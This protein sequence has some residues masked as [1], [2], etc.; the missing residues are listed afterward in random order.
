MLGGCSRDNAPNASA[1]NTPAAPAKAINE[2]AS[3][4]LDLDTV[5]RRTHFGDRGDGHTFSAGHDSYAVEASAETLPIWPSSPPPTSDTPADVPNAPFVASIESIQRGGQRLSRTSSAVAAVREDATLA[6]TRGNVA[7]HLENNEEGVEQSFE[8]ATRPE[9]S[10]DLEINIAVSGQSFVGATEGGLHFIDPVSAIGVR[11]GEA[12]WVDAQGTRT[13][14]DADFVDGRIVLRVPE[15]LLDSSVY[16]AVLDP[17]IGPEIAIDAPVIFPGTGG[18]QFDPAVSYAGGQYLVVWTDMRFAVE[19]IYGVRVSATGTLLDTTGVPISIAGGVQ[20]NPVV[21]TDGTNWMVAWG[22]QAEMFATRITAAGA[23][24]D[25]NGITVSVGANCNTP[26][27]AFDGTNYFIAYAQNGRYVRGRFVSPNG[28]PSPAPTTLLTQPAGSAQSVDVGLAW[29]GTNYLVADLYNPGVIARRVDPTGTVLDANDIVLCNSQTSCGYPNLAVASNGADWL[30]GWQGAT[31]KTTIYGARVSASGARLDPEGGFAMGSGI[32]NTYPYDLSIVYGAGDY[33][34]FWDDRN[35]VFG[36]RVNAAGTIVAPA[37]PLINEPGTRTCPAATFDGANYYVAFREDRV[38]GLYDIYGLRVSNSLVPLTPTSTLLN[39]Q[40]HYEDFVKVAHNGTKYLAVWQDYRSG[41]NADIY[42]ARISDTGTVLDPAGIAISSGAG[43]NQTIPDVAA[44]GADWLVVWNDSRLGNGSNSIYA[45]RVSDAG[46]VLDPA[47]FRVNSTYGGQVPSVSADTTNWFV[48]WQSGSPLQISGAR[49][50]PGGTVLDAGDIQIFNGPS[51]EPK[52]A[53]NGT[54]YLVV[55]KSHDSFGDIYGIRVTPAGTVLNIPALA[56]PISTVS[57]AY[58]QYP[59]ITSNGSDWLVGWSTNTDV[60][61]A[62]VDAAGNVLDPTGITISPLTLSGLGRPQ[63]AWDGTQYWYLWSDGP[64]W[65]QPASS[66]G[67]RL[68]SNAIVKDPQRFIAASDAFASEVVNGLAAGQSQHLGMV[69]GRDEPTQPFGSRRAKF[70]LISEIPA[71]SNGAACSASAQCSSG[72]CVDGVCCDS[73]C[74]G[75]CEACSALARGAGSDGVCAPMTANTDP[76]NECADQG[77]ASCGTNGKCSGSSSC[78]LYPNGTACDSICMGPGIQQR[79]CNGSGS[80]VVNGALSSCEPYNCTGAICNFSCTTNADCY[81]GYSCIGNMCQIGFP[82]GTACAVNADCNSGLCVDNVC[83][84]TD[85]T[86]LCE[87]C[88]NSKKGFGPDGVCQFI[89]TGLDPDNDCM[90]DGPTSCGKTGQCDGSGACEIRALGTPCGSPTCTGTIVE[91]RICD[92]SGFCLPTG[93]GQNCA[94]YA[95]VNG[96]CKSHCA[97]N[98]DCASGYACVMGQCVSPAG[99]GA[100]C[101]LA[102]QCA[103]GNCVDGVCCDSACAGLCQACSVIKKGSGMDGVC[104]TIGQGS[105]PDNE[106]VQQAATTCGQT[107]ACNGAGTCQLYPQGTSCG[108]SICQGTTAAGQ[109]C[110]GAGQCVASPMGVDCAPYACSSGACKNP[111]A[112]SNDCVNGYTCSAGIC[113]PVG[114]LGTP[115]T[116]ANQC[117]SGHCVD[118]VCCDMA[119]NGSCVACTVAKAGQGSDGV[120]GSIKAGTDPDDECAGQLPSSCGQTGFC[121]GASACA[122]YGMGTECAPGSCSA[123][124]QTNPSQCDGLGTCVA[125]S[126]MPCVPGYACNG[127]KCA[128]SCTT[129]NECAM[130]Y[131]CDPMNQWCVPVMGMGGNG[132][133]ASSG[134]GGSAGSGQGGSGS[135]ASGGEGGVAGMAG[136]GGSPIAPPPGS[137]TACNCRM[138]STGQTEGTAAGVYF[139]LAAGVLARRRRLRQYLAA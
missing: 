104:G 11:Y 74:T 49:V 115:C 22:S 17:I 24:L 116:T 6:I 19:D 61:A 71:G 100:T 34:I 13:H 33:A 44:R 36:A 99:N 20:E 81:P 84:D 114:T 125:G 54:N 2:I 62:R 15:A 128:T 72:F 139:V 82:Q 94:P 59:T 118:G 27:I 96:A 51:Y 16:P 4:P 130:G 68:T 80:C 37:A 91:T 77:A 97:T 41:N 3:P 124:E 69:Y 57:G 83:C 89:S 135:S 136:S 102:A 5:M 95:C 50:S 87:A 119:C 55:W 38:S 122:K 70:R 79:T 107:G 123:G 105:D 18:D 113:Q 111:C 52:A 120:C 65:S 56:I 66:Y 46:V 85:C 137:T 117:G 30:V 53:F 132:G 1:A 31:F 8:F 88:S 47:G 108:A 7:E 23:V 109:I 67:V 90:S 32:V 29:N 106:C 42:G 98:A 129:N 60:R 112:T 58:E 76:A 14:V 63:I 40:G 103:S 35:Q 45:T 78:A 86:G 75:T 28:T 138:V 131:E 10:G 26:A 101:A 21:A 12:T 133:S 25:P 92:G 93:T 73:A 134:Q 64:S 39:N 110:N 126:Q 121:N 127:N 9:G 48:V 43:S